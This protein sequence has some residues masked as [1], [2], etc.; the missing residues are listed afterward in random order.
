MSIS[1]TTGS[2]GELSQSGTVLYR[3]EYQFRMQ[4]RQ[5]QN[6]GK[7]D[8]L[9]LAGSRLTVHVLPSPHTLLA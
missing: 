9:A 7:D 3:Y 6:F 1:L 2:L 5:S 4:F 8:F